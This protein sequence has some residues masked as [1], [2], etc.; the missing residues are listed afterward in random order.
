MDQTQSEKMLSEM[1]LFLQTGSSSSALNSADDDDLP[2]E[3][4]D[5]YSTDP[6]E[7]DEMSLRMLSKVE[8]I[9]D[10]TRLYNRHSAKYLKAC[11]LLD[12]GI[13]HLAVCCLTKIALEVNKKQTP[14]LGQLSTEKLYGMASLNFRKLDDALSEKFR[15]SY[16]LYPELTNMHMR[17]FNLLLRLRST[18]T[19]IHLFLMRKYYDS[20]EDPAPSHNGLAFSK[21][22]WNR[23]FSAEKPEPPSFR[24]A[25]A[26]PLK[27]TGSV[28]PAETSAAVISGEEDSAEGSVCRSVLNLPAPA[29]SAEPES[30]DCADGHVPEE[31]PIHEITVTIDRMRELVSDPLFCAE[32]PWM[33]QEF[34]GILELVDS[35]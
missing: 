8:D 30:P 35:T 1:N 12:K 15:N 3:P 5:L 20:H 21:K 14:G 13:R 4:L 10:L 2:F 34:R 18:D 28:Y 9:F 27:G 19:K 22:S 29:D 7:F 6:V 16:E 32:H 33:V 25:P 17:F 26:F 24:K 23:S 31:E 11:A